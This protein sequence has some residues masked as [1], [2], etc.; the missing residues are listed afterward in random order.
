MSGLSTGESYTDDADGNMITC[1]ENGQTYTQAFD[2]ENRLI[3]V[4]GAATASFAYDGDGNRVK[5]TVSGVT[6][7]FLGNYYEW[8]SGTAT[9]YYY[10]GSQ[11]VAMRAGSTLYYLLGDHL[12][13]TSITT[14]VS[15]TL[16]SELLY[17]P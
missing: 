17:K 4:S 11:R 14:N 13:S 7:T 10:A 12:G 15:G 9:K 3:S 2:I 1:L 16:V 6:T 8:T 5:A